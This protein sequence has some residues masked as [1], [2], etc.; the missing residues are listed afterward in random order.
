MNQKLK[1]LIFGVILLGGGLFLGRM[2]GTAEFYKETAGTVSELYFEGAS[3]NLNSHVTL[4]NLLRTNETEKCQKQLESL[5]DVDLLAL[6]EYSKVPKSAR[7]VEILKSIQKAKEYRQK[8]PS[9][10]SEEVSA[11]IKKTLDLVK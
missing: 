4:L 5:V 3:T 8:Y 9:N 10:A 1:Q 7:K 11:S 6:A 2:I